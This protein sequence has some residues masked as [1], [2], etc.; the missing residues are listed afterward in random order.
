MSNIPSDM[1]AVLDKSRDQWWIYYLTSDTESPLRILKGPIEGQ[2]EDESPA[3]KGSTIPL[4]EV[5]PQPPSPPKPGNTQLGVL[6]WFDEATQKSQVC[7]LC[8]RLMR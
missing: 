2:R 8:Q 1:V 6:E 5:K 7:S 4:D 3:Y